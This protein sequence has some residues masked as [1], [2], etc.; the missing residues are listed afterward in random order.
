LLLAA[1]KN[2]ASVPATLGELFPDVGYSLLV[3]ISLD[4]LLWIIPIGNEL[5]SI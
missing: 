4:F 3:M 5:L 1:R 2:K